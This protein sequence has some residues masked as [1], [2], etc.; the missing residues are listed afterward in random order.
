LEGRRIEPFGVIK[1]LPKIPKRPFRGVLVL[2]RNQLDNMNSCDVSFDAQIYF[3]KLLKFVNAL[4]AKK[5]K[6]LIKFHGSTSSDIVSQFHSEFSGSQNVKIWNGSLR[7]RFEKRRFGP[8]YAYDS[9][10]LLETAA[11]DGEFFAAVFD[12][13][14]MLKPEIRIHYELTLVRGNLLK[15]EPEYAAEAVADWIAKGTGGVRVVRNFSKPLAIKVES[16]V[17]KLAYLLRGSISQ[18]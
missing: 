2:P 12:G 5:V 1:P 16:K 17:Q 6:V 4:D 9:T 11:A 13:L 7:N 15:T 3:S 8:V 10:G 14:G 18:N